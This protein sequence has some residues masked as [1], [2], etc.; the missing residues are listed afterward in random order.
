MACAQRLK[1]VDGHIVFARSGAQREQP[2][3][4]PFELVRIEFG[5]PQRSLEARARVF[6]RMQ[7]ELQRFDGRGY[8]GGRLSA[9]P[10]EPAQRRREHGQRRMHAAESVVRIPQVG[11]DFLRLHHQ[12]APLGQ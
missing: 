5:S 2:L 11:G 10:I 3:L 7:C 8:Q 12:R 4:D 1:V 9:A 6:Q